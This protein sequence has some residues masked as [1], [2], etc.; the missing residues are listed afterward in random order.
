LDFSFGFSDS[1][2]KNL[3]DGFSDIGW[4]DV[5]QSTSTTKVALHTIK[6]NGIFALFFAYGFYLKK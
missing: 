4:I 1:W 6:N 2:I 5:Y 3:L